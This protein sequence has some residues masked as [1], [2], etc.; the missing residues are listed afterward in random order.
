M[1]RAQPDGVSHVD[2][3]QNCCTRACRNCL[4]WQHGA[5]DDTGARQGASGS[6]GASV[7]VCSARPWSAV[8]SP[9][10][11][12]TTMTATAAVAGSGSTTPTATSW[13]VFAP[14]IT[15]DH[16]SAEENSAWRDWFTPTVAAP[17]RDETFAR[18][19][20]F[21]I[22]VRHGRPHPIRAAP[23][24]PGCPPGRVELFLDH[25]FNPW[26][27]DQLSWPAIAQQR[28]IWDRT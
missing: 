10:A 5:H 17:G 26:P 20:R 7:Q 16:H 15:N 14:A 2:Q 18:N 13:A 12:A 22:S 11:M 28:L 25:F 1:A 8:R 19:V 9:P 21:V 4:R 23:D 3:D 24:P 27:L 6:A